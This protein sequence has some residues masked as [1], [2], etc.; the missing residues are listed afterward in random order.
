MTCAVKNQFGMNPR[1]YKSEYHTYLAE[2]LVD[3]NRLYWPRLVVVDGDFVEVRSGV[4]KRYGL[5]LVGTD[6]A[7]VDFV[8]A[9]IFKMKPES[10][11]YL[12]HFLKSRETPLKVE[13]LGKHVSDCLI[14]ASWKPPTL[15]F[16]LANTI[17]KVSK[18]TSEIGA[19]GI[20][21]AGLMQDVSHY[22]ADTPPRLI[23]LAL[24]RG[25]H[26]YRF[27]KGQEKSTGIKI[28]EKTRYCT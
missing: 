24:I 10:I 14:E 23:P 1:R 5:L 13:V 16:R 15:L 22:L 20:G 6:P 9:Q 8:V 25:F 26:F 4:A 17:V 3:L 27:L 11:P 21:L 19:I 12:K 18:R 28:I 2:A 7:A